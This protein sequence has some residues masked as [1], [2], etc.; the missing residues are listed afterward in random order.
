MTPILKT[1]VAADSAASNGYG[2][3]LLHIPKSA[4]TLAGFR[5]WVLSDEF[6]EK[7]P[8]TFLKGEIFLDM[9][10]EAIRTHSAVKTAVAGTLFN[11]NQECDFADVYTNGV[12]VTNVEAEVSNNP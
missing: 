1:A 10:K 9:S 6:P 3:L 7:Q 8:V 4:H 5:A 2:D 11:L 12:L